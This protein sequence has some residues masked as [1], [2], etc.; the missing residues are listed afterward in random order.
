[1]VR[2]GVRSHALIAGAADEKAD[3]VAAVSGGWR[4]AKP[5]AVPSPNKRNLIYYQCGSDGGCRRRAIPAVT[6]ARYCAFSP[7]IHRAVTVKPSVRL[8]LTLRRRRRDRSLPESVLTYHDRYERSATIRVM[9]YFPNRTRNGQESRARCLVMTRSGHD[10]VRLEAEP[11]TARRVEADE[12][13][14]M[15]SFTSSKPDRSPAAARRVDDQ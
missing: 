8:L 5:A 4:V 6:S 11:P 7:F 1:M 9:L 12:T 15:T 2:V 14:P 3:F 10:A 13:G